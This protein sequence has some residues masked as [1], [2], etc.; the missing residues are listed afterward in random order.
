MWCILEFFTFTRSGGDSDKIVLK[1][2]NP[3]GMAQVVSCLDIK[4]ASCYHPEDKQRILAIIESSYGSSRQFNAACKSIL[5]GSWGI[6]AGQFESPA[7][8]VAAKKYQ[9]APG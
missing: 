1:P 2:L 9:V 5:A 6:F 4:R 8:K 7:K 3:D